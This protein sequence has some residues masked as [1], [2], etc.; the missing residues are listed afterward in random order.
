MAQSRLSHKANKNNE[1]KI[2]NAMQADPIVRSAYCMC[3]LQNVPCMDTTSVSVLQ[4][5]FFCL[6]SR[7]RCHVYIF[8]LTCF[9]VGVFFFFSSPAFYPSHTYL[10]CG[11]QTSRLSRLSAPGLRG[12]E[13]CPIK[14]LCVV[15]TSFGSQ[16]QQTPTLLGK[17]FT[18]SQGAASS[19]PGLSAR[20]PANNRSC[21]R[22]SAL[23][24]R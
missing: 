17:L 21:H 16:W 3:L 20:L 14:K 9:S 8:T 5:I 1:R 7:S 4:L 23:Y 19:Q 11:I 2:A 22:P 12:S 24:A 6:F 10:N 15:I 13:C 18:W